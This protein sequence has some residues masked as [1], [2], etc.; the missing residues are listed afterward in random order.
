MVLSQM[1]LSLTSTDGMYLTCR[2]QQRSDVRLTHIYVVTEII[3]LYTK[4]LFQ[5]D[6]G[7]A[8][9][10]RMGDDKAGQDL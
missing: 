5:T 1:L 8:A 6:N 9:E 4:A 10:S 2:G 7:E 3:S